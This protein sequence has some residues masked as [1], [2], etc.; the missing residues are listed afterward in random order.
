MRRRDCCTHGLDLPLNEPIDFLQRLL[1]D[2]PSD[3]GFRAGQK[4]WSRIGACEGE[5]Q[6]STMPERASSATATP[7]S[8]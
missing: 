7:A 3:H 8:G 4:K 1:V 2:L 6:R 5:A